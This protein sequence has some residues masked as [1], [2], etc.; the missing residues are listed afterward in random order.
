MPEL[1]QGTSKGYLSFFSEDITQSPIIIAT[2]SHDTPGPQLSDSLSH[3]PCPIV[4][5]GLGVGDCG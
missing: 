5:P 3:S 1:A 2:C 4:C